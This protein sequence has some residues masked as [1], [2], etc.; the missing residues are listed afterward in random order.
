MN[1]SLL[2]A[3]KN[4]W[5]FVPYAVDF[6]LGKKFYFKPSLNLFNNLKSFQRI[7]H[8]WIGLISYYFLGRI[9]KIY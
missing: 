5:K 3:E 7:S 9:D 1:R 6:K 4:N 2:I 8:E